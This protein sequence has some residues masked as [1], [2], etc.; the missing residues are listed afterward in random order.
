MEKY[1]V[2]I[3]LVVLVYYLFNC[4]FENKI[5]N[6]LKLKEG[7]VEETCGTNNVIDNADIAKSINTLAQITK[8]LQAGGLTVPG[9][10]NIKGVINTDGDITTKGKISA[11][12]VVTANKDLIVNG[13]FS[14]SS[15]GDDKI[16]NPTN[17]LRMN[18]I[19]IQF[20]GINNGRE[21]DSAQ[22]TAG[23]HE[24]DSLYIVGMSTGKDVN[25]RKVNMWAEGGFRVD[26]PL[27]VKKRDILQEIKDIER[28]I[29]FNG[30]KMNFRPTH[31]DKINGNQ[32]SNL[33]NWDHPC[34]SDE[35]NKWDIVS[36]DKLKISEELNKIKVPEN[37][38]K[39]NNETIQVINQANSFFSNLFKK[40]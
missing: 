8:D 7:F 38:I 19:G 12:G 31:I 24:K 28:D 11:D 3:I 22:I 32:C 14:V 35:S 40:K 39:L 36:I 27:Y 6:I 2:I 20:G 21:I 37:I 9:A 26:G 33:F 1:L 5:N 25:T 10:L 13:M 18:N 4:W 30:S 23:L 15:S 16:Q 17:D 34:G 29:I